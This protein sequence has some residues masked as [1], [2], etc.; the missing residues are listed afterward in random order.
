ML[1]RQGNQNLKQGIDVLE[2]GAYYLDLKGSVGTLWA[3]KISKQIFNI[4]KYK[5]IINVIILVW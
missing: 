3:I 1:N 5:Y 4:T 2:S